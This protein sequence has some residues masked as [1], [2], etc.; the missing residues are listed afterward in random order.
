MDQSTQVFIALLIG[1][2]VYTTMKGNL[3]KWANVLGL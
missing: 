3:V 1:Y 2:L